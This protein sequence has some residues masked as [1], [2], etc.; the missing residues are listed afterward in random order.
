MFVSPLKKKID[1]D[2]VLIQGY[3]AHKRTPPSRQ[4]P[5]I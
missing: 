4:K 2:Y 3:T 5:K 1:F